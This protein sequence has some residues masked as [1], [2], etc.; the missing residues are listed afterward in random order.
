MSETLQ[1]HHQ[2]RHG[3]RWTADNARMYV[4]NQVVTGVELPDGTNFRGV[5]YRQDLPEQTT[6]LTWPT[7]QS[8]RVAEYYQRFLTKDEVGKAGWNC[9]SFVAHVMGWNVRWDAGAYP[10][11]M[12][13]KHKSTPPTELENGVPYAVNKGVLAPTFTHSV[14]GLA[15]PTHNL[16]VNGFLNQLYITSNE[17]TRHQYAGNFQEHVA[18]RIASR[19]VSHLMGRSY[20]PIHRENRY[21]L[22]PSLL[23]KPMSR[24]DFLKLKIFNAAQNSAQKQA[25]P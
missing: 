18:P 14:M 13:F 11:F 22:K 2:L 24:R 19:A 9:H 8:E 1:L 20:I 4:T 23:D 16:G 7:E 3:V 21:P 12:P 17:T 10:Y 5:A 25:N 6:T 15:D